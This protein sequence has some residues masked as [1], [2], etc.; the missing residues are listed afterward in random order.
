LRE[1]TRGGHVR[2]DHTEQVDP[3]WRGHTL[4]VRGADTRVTTTFEPVAEQD[5]T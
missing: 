5:L 2:S 1:E 3:R 4:L